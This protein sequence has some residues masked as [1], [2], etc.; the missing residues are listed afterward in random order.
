[1]FKIIVI[2]KEAWEQTFVNGKKLEPEG[3]VKENDS[4]SSDNMQYGI[5][6]HHLDRI[7]IGIN[8]LFLFKYPLMK[9]RENLLAK[10]LNISLDNAEIRSKLASTGVVDIEPQSIDD[11]ICHDYTAEQIE[12]DQDAIDFDTSYDEAKQHE[13]NQKL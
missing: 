5:M 8:T 1:M 6:L 4:I 3:K 2:G 7:F 12:K 10:E 9:H 13:E 11:L